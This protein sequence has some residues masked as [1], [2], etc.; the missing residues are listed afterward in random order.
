LCSIVVLPW[1]ER[2]NLLQ[3][4]SMFSNISPK[5]NPLRLCKQRF[6]SHEIIYLREG[7]STLSRPGTVFSLCYRPAGRKVVNKEAFGT[8]LQFVLNSST[9]PS[10]KYYKITAHLQLDS[11]SAVRWKRTEKPTCWAL[12]PS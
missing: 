12:W 10:S 3:L 1:H 4:L 11:S 8:P 5:T 9:L 7:F 2:F 6:A